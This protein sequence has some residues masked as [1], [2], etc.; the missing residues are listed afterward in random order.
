MKRGIKAIIFDI[1]GVLEL[2]EYATQP[3]RGHR[4]LSV[5]EYVSTKLGI[6]LDHYFDSID[7]AYA[8]SMEGKIS[9]KRLLYILSKNFKVS[10]RKIEKL[11]LKAYKKNFKHNKKLYNFAF[12][13]REQGYQIA[14]LSD[15]WHLS[16]LALMPKKM[17]SKFDVVV[18]S[19]DVGVRKPDQKIYRMV[20]KQLR[21]KA[22]EVLFIDNREWNLIPA[23]KIGMKTILFKN[24]EQLFKEL[25]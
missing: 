5:H 13:L 8:R 4:E 2:G 14:I 24:N 22:K 18:V 7:S 23:K 1:G 17:T 9:K 20:L 12:K 15:Q 11:Y 19:C 21:V 25:K 16:K 3:K 10:S 6:S